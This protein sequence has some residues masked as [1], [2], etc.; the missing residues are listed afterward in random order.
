[1]Q[2]IKIRYFKLAFSNVAFFMHVFIFY[3]KGTQTIID[4]TIYIEM[5]L[6]KK[7]TFDLKRLHFPFLAIKDSFNCVKEGL[8]VS[9]LLLSGAPRR[10]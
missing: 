4:F 10:I 9:S 7:W 5:K 3:L 2:K 8:P 1:M 6:L